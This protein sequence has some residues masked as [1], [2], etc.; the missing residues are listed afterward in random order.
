[1]LSNCGLVHLEI[2]V[3]LFEQNAYFLR[4]EISSEVEFNL[5]YANSRISSRVDVQ[6]NS[7]SVQVL[8]LR[9]IKTKL[10]YNTV[11]QKLNI[12]LNIQ[13]VKYKKKCK[14]ISSNWIEN[15]A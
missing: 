11:K 8:L 1:M 5:N 15:S 9:H 12:K 10:L 6:D 4:I 2:I 13:R 14:S 3:E 7:A